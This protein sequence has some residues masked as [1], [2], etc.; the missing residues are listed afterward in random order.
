MNDRA[1]GLLEQY[2]VEVLRTRKGRG[3]ILCDTP[4]GCLIFKEYSGN[5]EKI[6]IQN[7]VL[8]HIRECGKV[9]AETLIATREGELLV[10][11]GDGT[12]YLLKTYCEGRECNI[13]DRVECQEAVRQLARLHQC[14]EFPADTEWLPAGICAGKEYDKHNRELRR[15]KKYLQQKS[16]KT[17]FEIC[18]LG[19]FDYFLNQALTVAAEWNDYQ[20]SREKLQ[21]YVYFCHGDY[22]Y[23]NI[24]LGENGCFLIN[25]EKCVPDSP[26]RDLYLLLRKLLEKS[27]WSV[28]MGK[29]LLGA[30]E[31]IQ[32]IPAIDRIDLYYRLSYP[33][34]FW[35]I[36]NFYYNSGKAWIPERNAEKLE[37]LLRQEKEKQ[38]FLE[39]VFRKVGH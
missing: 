7:R 25:F 21:S 16:Q 23:H 2:D 5:E 24:L 17:G 19:T 33:E 39:E 34:K 37:K 32:P 30:Y 36:A 26:M 14:M 9:Q 29:E 22:Q 12:I 13:Y 35:K 10:R 15:V 18:L 27:G 11:D 1:V 20:R 8:E 38:S 4:G 28:A 3:S 6:R 31:E